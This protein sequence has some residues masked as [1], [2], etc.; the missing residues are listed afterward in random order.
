MRKYASL[1]LVENCLH[2]QKFVNGMQRVIEKELGEQY[3]GRGSLGV[4]IMLTQ[5]IQSTCT[6]S[7]YI[8]LHHPLKSSD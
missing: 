8:K 7:L 1:V 2:A 6:L 5:Q 3:L 4:V